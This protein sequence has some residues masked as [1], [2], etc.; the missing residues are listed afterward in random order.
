MKRLV[1]LF[2][3]AVTVMLPARAQD[4]AS[5]ETMQAARELA[6]PCPRRR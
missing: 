2:L 3:L 5:P 1:G 6:Y 4:K